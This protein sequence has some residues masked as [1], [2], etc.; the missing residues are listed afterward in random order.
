[1]T[2]DD[3]ARAEDVL[4]LETPFGDFE[5][6]ADEVVRFPDG[7]PGFEQS[8]AFVVLSGQTLAPLQCLHAVDGE[9][10]S[11]LA[12]DPRRVLPTYRCQLSGPDRDRL[13]DLEDTPLLWLVLITIDDA[14]GATVNLRAPVVINPAAM[15]GFQV[16]PH[17]SLYPAR[18][19]LVL[20]ESESSCS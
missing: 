9:Q 5:A 6:G 14:G 20:D 7:L 2:R 17:D 16:M 10:A 4:R 8:R 19:P 18:H 15:T 1:M 13:G 3:A 11:F 12:I